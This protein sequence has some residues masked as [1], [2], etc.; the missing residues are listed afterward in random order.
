[1]ANTISFTSRLSIADDGST[2]ASTATTATTVNVESTLG[3]AK[4][5]A[6]KVGTG[7]FE[8]I[9]TGDVDLEEEY[10]LRLENKDD[11]NY[12]EVK[13]FVDAGNSA[14]CAIMRPGEPFGPIRCPAQ[15]AGYPKYQMQAN[16]AECKV[17]V[18][19][20]EAGDPDA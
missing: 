3:C 10:V 8:D 19:V 15:T 18:V 9:D 4:Q 14:V 17:E 11:T 6:Q 7:A 5:S 2:Y 1:M 12:V 13:F 20:G 16:T